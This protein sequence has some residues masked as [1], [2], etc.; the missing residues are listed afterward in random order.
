ME[1]KG[2]KNDLLLLNFVSKSRF[3]NVVM[4]INS[5]TNLEK[6]NNRIKSTT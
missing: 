4:D 2:E 1:I 5:L 3:M 6:L